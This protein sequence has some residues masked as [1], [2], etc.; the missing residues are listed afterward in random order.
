MLKLLLDPSLVSP[1]PD[2]TELA[3]RQHF[4]DCGTVEGVRLIRDRD[5]GMGKGFGYVLFEVRGSFA[6]FYLFAV[7]RPYQIC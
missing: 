6:T 5:T 2:V 7:F 3:L 1:L 4:E